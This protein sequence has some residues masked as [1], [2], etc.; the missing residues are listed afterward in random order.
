VCIKYKCVLDI[1]CDGTFCARLVA[2]RYSQ[3]PGLD[4]QESFTPVINNVLFQILIVCQVIWG[5]AAVLEVYG[6]GWTNAGISTKQ[7]Y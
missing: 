6:M 7:L 5:L 4:F 2:C 3:V 1:K